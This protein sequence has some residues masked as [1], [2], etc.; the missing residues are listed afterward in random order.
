MM[1]IKKKNGLRKLF[2]NIGLKSSSLIN[3]LNLVN[4]KKVNDLMDDRREY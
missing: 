1:I 3:I 4:L 2:R